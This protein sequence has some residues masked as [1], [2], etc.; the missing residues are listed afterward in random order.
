M[1]H[2]TT[3]T[4]CAHAPVYTVNLH[5]HAHAHT[6]TH[7]RYSR[8]KHQRASFHSAFF[9]SMYTI[10]HAEAPGILTCVIHSERCLRKQAAWLAFSPDNESS[11]VATVGKQQ[12]TWIPQGA[13]S[14]VCVLTVIFSARNKRNGLSCGLME[15]GELESKSLRGFVMRLKKTVDRLNTT[16]YK[17]KA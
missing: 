6:H 11:A 12:E 14:S 17:P 8:V 3:P 1:A 13:F 4:T 16:W 2:T 7:T 15:P 9:F 5:R 10:N